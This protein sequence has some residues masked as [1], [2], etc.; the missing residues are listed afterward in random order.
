LLEF[1]HCEAFAI[2]GEET[3]ENL[4]L[5]CRAHN[6][7]EAEK[8]FGRNRMASAIASAKKAHVR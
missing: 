7:F 2:G 5:R 4:R 8:L 1:D 3:V 6:V